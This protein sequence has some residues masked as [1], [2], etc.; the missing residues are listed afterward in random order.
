MVSD[1]ILGPLPEDWDTATLGDA[2]RC[3]GGDVQTG[4]FGSQL[5]ASD[6]LDDGVPSIMPQN[7]GENRVLAQ[8]IARYSR[9]GDVERRALIREEQDGWLCGTGCLRVRVGAGVADPLFLSYYLGHPDVRSWIVRHAI[10]ATMLNLNTSIL[11]ALP[12]VLPPLPEQHAI[13]AI[14]GALDDKIELNRRM[15]QTLEAMAQALFKSW[16][17]DF[18]PV[19]AKAEGRRP[20][21]MDAETT[22]LFPDSFEYSELGETPSGWELAPLSS[23]SEI[24]SGG[25]PKTNVSAFWGGDIPWVSVADTVPGPYITYTQKTITDGGVANSAA[26]LLPPETVIIT[27][28][29]TVGNTALISKPMAINQSCYGLVG[30]AEIGQLFLLH[31]VRDHVSRLKAA[32]HGSVFETITRSTF[33]AVLVVR[34]ANAAIHKFE[35]QVRPLFDR[36][37]CNQRESA[38]LADIRDALLPKLLSGEIRAGEARRV[39]EAAF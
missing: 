33:D 32:A 31:L 22:A 8:G 30:R 37:L 9:R 38:A 27:A 34:P 36:I 4:P 16:F 28:R 19:R 2:C 13:A 11:S 7:I 21:G 12:V 10:G 39:A 3:G 23:V 17:V 18:D 35:S 6:F 29:G 1:T 25:N 20:F 15:K 5:H 14:L 26:A 24:L